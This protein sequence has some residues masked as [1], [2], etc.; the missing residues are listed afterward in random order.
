MRLSLGVTINIGNFENLRLDVESEVTEPKDTENLV[1]TLVTALGT[2]GTQDPPTKAAI[3]SYL[4][5]VFGS[6]PVEPPRSPPPPTPAPQPPQEESPGVRVIMPA[7]IRPEKPP[8]A[9]KPKVA[10]QQDLSTLTEETVGAHWTAVEAEVAA[11]GRDDQDRWAKETIA[12]P[13]GK[14][15]FI[16]AL[17]RRIFADRERTASAAKQSPPREP[18][19]YLP[20]KGGKAQGVVQE[21]QENGIKIGGHILYTPS[22]VKALIKREKIDTNDEV[23]FW[24]S[25]KD[26]GALSNI[27]FLR[28]GT[29]P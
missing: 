2:L 19:M 22:E 5:R 14:P 28:R 6:P 10:F 25:P 24:I 16:I 11:M 26:E 18:K 29:K 23:E 21:I 27:R 13:H 1:G 12:D 3:D 8:E 4:H 20:E 9:P 7:K 15:D 17:A